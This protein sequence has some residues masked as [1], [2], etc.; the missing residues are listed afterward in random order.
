[1]L[2]NF[3][4]TYLTFATLF[5]PKILQKLY[6]EMRYFNVKVHQNM[7]AFC[8]SGSVVNCHVAF[9]HPTWSGESQE[10]AKEGVEVG[11]RRELGGMHP[12]FLK[13]WST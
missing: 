5:K 6:C 1:M 10:K 11:E 2:Y 13:A 3:D 8:R 7:P 9:T 4:T 12:A